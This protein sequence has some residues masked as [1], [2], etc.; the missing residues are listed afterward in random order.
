MR[1]TMRMTDINHVRRAYL[2]LTEAMTYRWWFTHIMVWGDTA[3]AWFSSQTA[4]VSKLTLLPH[5]HSHPYTPTLKLLTWSSTAII[6]ILYHHH[7]HPHSH[8]CHGLLYPLPPSLDRARYLRA[9]EGWS[10]TSSETVVFAWGEVGR[11]AFWC[12]LIQVKIICHACT[13][14]MHYMH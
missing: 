13:G 14:I 9:C 2:S 6:L 11:C 7:L 12:A 3:Q 1:M 4:N 10:V 8:S 5:C